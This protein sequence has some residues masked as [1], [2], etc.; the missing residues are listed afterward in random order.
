MDK[1]DKNIVYCRISIGLCI[2]NSKV[3]HF[4]NR[5]WWIKEFKKSNERLEY[6]LNE[7]E[8]KKFEECLE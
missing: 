3:G 6:L 8:I 7:K 5:E 2:R 4:K 1:L